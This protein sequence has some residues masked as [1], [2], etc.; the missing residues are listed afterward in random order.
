MHENNLCAFSKLGMTPAPHVQKMK[1][2]SFA[3]RFLVKNATTKDKRALGRWTRKELID[4]GPTFVKLG[5]TVSTRGD[6]YPVEFTRELESLQDSVPVTRYDDDLRVAT[7]FGTYDPEPFKSASIGQVYRA[8][9]KDGTPV[10]VKRKRPGVS[11]LMRKDCENIKD[12]VQFLEM[13][14]V[15]TGT[16]NNLVLDESIENLLLEADY[17][18]E[19]QNAIAFR[20][21]F[22]K[23]EWVKVPKVYQELSNDQ[24]IVMEYVPSVKLTELPRGV[25]ESK[26]CEALIT[27]YVLQTMEH[28]FFH[29]DP[30]PGNVA[31][32]ESGK[33]VFY[34]F[35]LCIPLPEEL[36]D[37]FMDL[38]VSIVQRDTKSIVD[39]LVKLKVIIPTSDLGDLQ[40]FFDNI[41]GYMERLDV[42]E[43]TTNI[44]DDELMMQLAQ[45][46]PFVIPFAFIYLAKAFTLIEGTLKKLDPEFNYFT[47]LE[48]L[49]QQR[50]S[51]SIDVRKVLET[52][53]AMPTTVKNISTAV[54]GLEKSR[55]AMKRSLKKTRREIRL[56]QYSILSTLLA[57]ECENAYLGAAFALMAVYF[58]FTSSRKNR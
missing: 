46:K 40:I 8:T 36:R 31:F 45:E 2:W 5:Q 50:V 11:E 22:K 56:A 13:L 16:G 58:V 44:M 10:I 53:T 1:T 32:S 19:I 24:M 20:K 28:G 48:P 6:I 14:G 29:A 38:L 35:G 4:L 23:V 55:A 25:N 51:D 7:L 27:S 3:A 18:H 52:T 33:L 34:D 37:G 49:I 17:T 43:F 57:F 26:V 12:I 47:Y 9:L 41:L 54:L 30:H 42:R 21:N 15:D 39:T